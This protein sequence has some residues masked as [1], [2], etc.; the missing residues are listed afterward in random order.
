MNLIEMTDDQLRDNIGRLAS[1]GATG[2]LSEQEQEELLGYQTELYNR[3]TNEMAPPIKPKTKYDEIFDEF[4]KSLMDLKNYL[5][6]KDADNS[7][8]NKEQD[9]N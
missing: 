3:I 1:K 9:N 7:K 5:D 8:G 6:S 4:Y 2:E